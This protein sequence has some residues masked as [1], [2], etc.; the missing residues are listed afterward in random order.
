MFVETVPQT[1]EK[2]NPQ[3]FRG[4]FITITR[5]FDG[6]YRPNFRPMKVG[7][8]FSVEKYAADVANELLWALGGLVGEER[9]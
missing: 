1:L 8:D 6:T 3:F 4:E 7:A 5:R 2:R 9:S